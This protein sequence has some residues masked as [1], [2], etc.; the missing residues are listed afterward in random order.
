MQL[1]CENRGGEMDRAAAEAQTAL[2]SRRQQPFLL[3]PGTN[4]PSL[5]VLAR[6][7]LGPT[8]AS[9]SRSLPPKS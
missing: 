9:V 5:A 7:D 1:Q 2:G 8:A 4:P 3:Q 6:A